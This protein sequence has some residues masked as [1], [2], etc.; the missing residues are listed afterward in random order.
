MPP[1]PSRLMYPTW[2]HGGR[3]FCGLGQSDNRIHCYS[4]N[5]RRYTTLADLGHTRLLPW[6]VAP[7]MGLDLDDSPMVMQDVSSMDLYALDWEA[8]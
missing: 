6:V 2:T 3:S 1:A 8:P 5:E 4:F 7:W